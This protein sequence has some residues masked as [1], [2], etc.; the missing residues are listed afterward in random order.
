MCYTNPIGPFG[1]TLG[2]YIPKNFLNALDLKSIDKL[3]DRYERFIFTYMV[4]GWKAAMNIIETVNKRRIPYD[5]H[6]YIFVPLVLYSLR[7]IYNEI[8]CDT[9]IMDEE[10]LFQYSIEK[11][12]KQ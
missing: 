2:E 8:I 5:I 4:S 9:S 3:K 10:L 12:G 7:Q 11:G 6:T 1:N